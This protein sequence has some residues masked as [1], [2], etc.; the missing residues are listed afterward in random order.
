MP[1]RANLLFRRLLREAL[2]TKGLLLVQFDF[3]FLVQESPPGGTA[4]HCGVSHCS[5]RPALNT[6]HFSRCKGLA[7]G[8]IIKAFGI[9]CGLPCAPGRAVR[10]PDPSCSQAILEPQCAKSIVCSE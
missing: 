8:K 2:A 5:M 10:P 6:R 4:V 7:W 9:V 3:F 1:S